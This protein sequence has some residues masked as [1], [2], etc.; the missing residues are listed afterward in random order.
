[1]NLLA[2]LLNRGPRY[3]SDEQR[4]SER[5]FTDGAES[6]RSCHDDGWCLTDHGGPPA[7]RH[8]LNARLERAGEVTDSQCRGINHWTINTSLY[9]QVGIDPPKPRHWCSICVV[10]QVLKKMR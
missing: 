5:E 10:E 4:E 7:S 1:M 3:W 2:Y 6:I 8:R 9:S